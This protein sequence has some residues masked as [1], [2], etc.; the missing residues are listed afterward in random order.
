MDCSTPGFPV[1]LSPGV[2][3][4]L[5]PLSWWCHPTMLSSVTLFSSC[6]QSFPASGSFR[7]SQ[8]F[9]IKGPSS[10]VCLLIRTT[11]KTCRSHLG[12]I[13]VRLKQESVFLTSTLTLDQ[14]MENAKCHLLKEC[15]LITPGRQMRVPL[16]AALTLC[17]HLCSLTVHNDA[18][19]P[20]HL[21]LKRKEIQPSTWMSI[22][23]KY[24]HESLNGWV[25]VLESSFDHKS[26]WYFS[27]VSESPWPLLYSHL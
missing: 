15:L 20:L 24:I 5:E 6:P 19:V 2:C 14:C 18:V 23:V 26:V 13:W 4:D 12:A 27:L 21:Y 17:S 8:L 3:S 11:W 25:L 10:L 7:M 16:P 9:C 22:N 1:L